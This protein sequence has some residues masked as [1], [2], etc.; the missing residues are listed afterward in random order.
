L[1]TGR[2]FDGLFAFLPVWVKL[3]E[4]SI[5]PAFAA[6]YLARRFWFVRRFSAETKPSGKRRNELSVAFLGW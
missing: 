2:T 1:S 6:D 4:K 3:T 5:A